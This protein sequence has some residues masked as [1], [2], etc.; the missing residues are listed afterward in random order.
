M[1]HSEFQ[2]SIPLLALGG[3]EA[4]EQ[5]QLEQHLAECAACRALLAEYTFVADELNLRAPPQNAPPNLYAKVASQVSPRA[6]PTPHPAFTMHALRAQNFWRQPARISRL[7]LALAS[8]VLI[9]LAFGAALVAFQFRTGSQSAASSL[10]ENVK[11][12][13]LDGTGTGPDGY[14]CLS[15]DNKTAMVWLTRLPLLDAEHAY[16]LWLIRN[17]ERRSG[18]L[19]RPRQDGR[20]IFWVE[21]QEPWTNFQEVGVTIEPKDGSPG[22]TTPRMLGG[23][24]D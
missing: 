23:K 21:S 2:E 1:L 5:A 11:V 9:G 8:L 14:I 18:G 7:T 3:L 16:Q 13:S 24:L 10:L 20:A 4:A 17:G 12:V 15:P 22:P 6:A 19:F